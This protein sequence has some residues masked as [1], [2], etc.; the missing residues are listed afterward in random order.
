MDNSVSL[1]RTCT[2]PHGL[3][4]ALVLAMGQGRRFQGRQVLAHFTS[5]GSHHVCEL[6]EAGPLCKLSPREAQVARR[7]A[8]GANAR[9]IASEFGASPSAVHSQIASVYRKLDISEKTRLVRLVAQ[10]D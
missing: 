2:A 3:P 1:S 6:R 4:V 7:F 9:E 10:S 8:Q 5:V